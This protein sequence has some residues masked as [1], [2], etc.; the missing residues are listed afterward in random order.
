MNSDDSSTGLPV[1]R[2]WRAVYVFV[3][4]ALAVWI[5]LLIALPWVC[6]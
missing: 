1:L 3:L 2:T 5:G 6:A 4:A